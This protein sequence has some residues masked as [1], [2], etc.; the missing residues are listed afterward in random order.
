MM[1]CVASRFLV[2]AVVSLVAIHPA[3]AV[4][5]EEL[6]KQ[7]REMAG[8]LKTLKDDNQ[9]LRDE[10]VELK[11]KVAS[12][13]QTK[14]AP[15]AKAGTK[16]ANAVKPA[17]TAAE[18]KLTKS[19][20]ELKS[21]NGQ[22]TIK[23]LSDAFDVPDSPA[24]GALGISPSKVQHLETPKQLIPS[25]INGL[26]EH[27][28]FQSGIAID[29][30]PFQ[31]FALHD[32]VAK[33]R[34]NPEQWAF[35]DD[36]ET[37]LQR[38]LLR[39][40]FS[41]A[42]AKGTSDDDKSSKL[43]FGIHSVLMNADDPITAARIRR[44]PNN[45]PVQNDRL[46]PQD[47]RP[48]DAFGR[49]LNHF[50]LS[51]ATDDSPEPF[52]HGVLDKSMLQKMGNHLWS[53][54][55]WAIGAAPELVAKDDKSDYRYAGTTAWSSFSYVPGRD[56]NF[57][58]L[59]DVIYRNG[60]LI[61]ASDAI[62]AKGATTARAGDELAE[63][64]LFVTGGFRYGTRD[65]NATATFSWLHLDDD[66][67]GSDSAF[68]Y[69]LEVEKRITISSFLTLSISKDE[70]RSGGHDPLLV[71]GG[72]KFGLGGRDFSGP[73]QQQRKAEHSEQ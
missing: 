5:M 37:Y 26:D 17:G 53:H 22:P 1:N 43:A 56:N 57:R 11:K 42:T 34:G 4:T 67:R 15:A 6:Q 30:A 73:E 20:S 38:V 72:V 35:L 29:F 68:R 62:P 3:S 40:Q 63:D 64:S 31:Y 23:D 46:S 52:G 27:G 45:E 70:G 55:S 66:G 36:A 25:I 69:G 7:M 18:T 51:D 10:Q 13:E 9:A 58:F 21:D 54:M 8:T 48:L 49:T 59:L 39:T 61:P 65:F 47:G 28:H 44:G 60:Q 16:T 32:P 2:I 33:Y 41:F 14:A 50:T 71:L 12:L 24:A 19:L